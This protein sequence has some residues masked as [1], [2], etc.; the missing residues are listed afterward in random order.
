MP[1]LI[2]LLLLVSCLK[3]PET[4]QN[5]NFSPET[6]SHYTKYLKNYNICQDSDLTLRFQLEEGDLD[7]KYCFIP[8]YF[9]EG[10]D[11]SIFV[12]EPR[13]QFIKSSKDVHEITFLKNRPSP[14]GAYPYSKFPT[15]GVLIIKDEVLDFGPPF[16]SPL[17]A[18]NA[19][20]KCAEVLDTTGDESYCLTFKETG[21]YSL[22]RF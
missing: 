16:K 20:L 19:Y 10:G 15:R 7:I 6:F 18:P 2:L 11:K 14:E 3:A 12:G 5:C 17:P 21:N 1:K 22:H 8:I 4:A 9:P 13:C